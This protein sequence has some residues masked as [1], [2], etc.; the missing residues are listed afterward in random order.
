[1]CRFL[2]GFRVW[3]VSDSDYFVGVGAD[4]VGVDAC[5]FA[6]FFLG[7]F[8]SAFAG[9]AG[10]AAAAFAAGGVVGVVP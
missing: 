10:A 6:F 3:T 5:F 9:A 8:A 7:F 2:Y 1:M 4:A